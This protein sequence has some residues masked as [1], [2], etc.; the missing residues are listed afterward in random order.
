MLPLP[1]LHPLLHP[2]MLPLLHPPMLPLLLLHPLQRTAN[3]THGIRLNHV[4]TTLMTT[5]GIKNKQQLLKLLLK[6]G[7]LVVIHIDL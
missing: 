6:M 2:P 4:V 7:V 3:L 5:N 1:L